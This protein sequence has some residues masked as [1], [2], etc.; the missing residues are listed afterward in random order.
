MA[1]ILVLRKPNKNDYTIPKAY[2][3]IALLNTIRKLLKLIIIRRFIN[4]AENHNLLSNTQMSA[5]AERF[6]ETAL[7]LITK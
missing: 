5:K 7:Q 3:S 6:I 1:I 2:K 4:F